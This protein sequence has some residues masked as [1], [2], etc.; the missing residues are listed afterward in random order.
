MW[1]SYGINLIAYNLCNWNTSIYLF[2]IS[3]DTCIWSALLKK[4]KK[5]SVY[6]I[7]KYI[8]WILIIWRIRIVASNVNK[9]QVFELFRKHSDNIRTS[10]RWV[11]L[12]TL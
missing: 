11:L 9:W 8:A 2:P 10:G 4:P 6:T 12:S 3:Y 1:I 5:L 7:Q